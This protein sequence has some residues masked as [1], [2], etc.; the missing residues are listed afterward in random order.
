MKIEFETHFG[1]SIIREL[2]LSGKRRKL[3]NVTKQIWFVLQ[4]EFFLAFPEILKTLQN[5]F[6]VS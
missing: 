5:I 2:C 3:S 4:L 1:M 6:F